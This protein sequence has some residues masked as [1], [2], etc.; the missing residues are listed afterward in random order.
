MLLDFSLLVF[1]C[2]QSFHRL[3]FYTITTNIIPPRFLMSSSEFCPST[4]PVCSLYPSSFK[5]IPMTHQKR[6]F[7]TYSVLLMYDLKSLIMLSSCSAFIFLLGRKLLLVSLNFLILK[8][9]YQWLLQGDVTF[10]REEFCI[11]QKLLVA[12]PYHKIID[13]SF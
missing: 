9:T 10:T 11:C 1:P 13:L 12:T 3:C 2:F 6:L 8:I 4:S 7:I 5:K